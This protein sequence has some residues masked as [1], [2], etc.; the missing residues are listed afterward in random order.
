MR[1]LLEQNYNELFINYNLVKPVE[2]KDLSSI[3]RNSLEDF[4]ERNKKV[5]IYCNGGHTKMLMSDFIFELKSVR[6]I[7]DNYAKK[8]DNQGFFMI[9]DDE[10]EKSGIDAVIISSFKFKDQIIK[11][12]KEEHPALH[13]LNIYDELAQKGIILHSDYYYCNHPYH[14]YHTLN[15]LQRKIHHSIDKSE[16][17]P[18]YLSIIEKYIQ[19]KDFKTALFY[20]KE[21]CKIRNTEKY[22]HMSEDLDNLYNM[23]KKAAEHIDKKNVLMFCMDGLRREDLSD[24]F[25]PKLTKNVNNKGFSF[26]NAY[27]VSTSTFESL[28]PAYSKN[29]DLSTAYYNRNYISEEECSFLKKAKNQDRSIYFYTDV[30]HIIESPSIHYSGKSQTVTEKIWDF[31]VDGVDEK[32][33]LFYIHESY[34]SHFTFSNPYTKER[35]ISEG[36]AMLF[37][38]LPQK[39]ESLRTNYE[40]QHMDALKYLDDVVSPFMDKLRCRIILYSDHG[41]MILKEGCR[42]KDVK[43][44]K[45]TCDEEWIRIAYAVFSPEMGVGKSNRLISLMSFDDIMVSLLDEQAYE[46][47]KNEYIKVVRSELYNPDFSYL[48]KKMNKEGYLLA[49]E[50]FIFHEGYKLVVYSDGTV[51]LFTV[52]NDTKI[53]N[54]KLIQRLI[55]K[56]EHS[57]TVCDIDN[58]NEFR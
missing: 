19:I 58:I 28:I 12:L 27:S 7:V 6:Y 36:T 54:K 49:F 42:L 44:T 30:E 9:R 43:E 5:A 32:N 21:L 8:S 50:A 17:E 26:E 51:E 23:E 38:F 25:M 56:I 52:E 46:I 10:I 15:S 45:L 1:Q 18:I 40:R 22:C 13:I 14:H 20:C 37:D 24:N 2:T 41:N 55:R 34:E 39:G 29:D 4:I 31:I 11:K 35:L 16:L 48:Y 53:M 33:G 3:I 47:P 57:I